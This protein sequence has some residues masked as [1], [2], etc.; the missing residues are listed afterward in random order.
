MQEQTSHFRRPSVQTIPWSETIYH[1][2]SFADPDGRVFLWEGD[3]YRGVFPAAAPFFRKLAE[4]GIISKL[5]EQGFLVDTELTPFTSKEFSLVFR[6]QIVP[7]A[8]YPQEWCSL[9]F[10]DAALAIVDFAIELAHD[11]LIL[12]DGHPWNILFDTCKPLYIDLGSIAPVHGSSIWPAYPDFCRYCLYPL[13]LMSQGYDLLGRLLMCEDRGVRE[14]ELFRLAP[15][16]AFKAYI[17]WPVNR[18][19]SY[20]EK[21]LTSMTNPLLKKEPTTIT[22]ESHSQSRNQKKLLSFLKQLR[23]LVESIPVSTFDFQKGV[24]ESPVDSAQEFSDVRALNGEGMKRLLTELHPDS[25]LDINSGKGSLAKQAASLGVRVVCFE[26]DYG[27]V[28]HLYSEAKTKGLSILPLV[29]DFTKP[30][31]ARGLGSHWAIAATERLQCDLV[32]ALDLLNQP[33]PRRL[34]FDK[35][36][37]GLSQFTK[38]W[39]VLEIPLV[40]GSNGTQPDGFSIDSCTRLLERQ[41]RNI[42]KIYSH[43]KGSMLLVC[44]K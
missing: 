14:R 5:V 9:M 4:N 28:S 27:N 12:K 17:R 34:G 38:R 19:L 31:P 7:F 20:T 11:D 13:I 44:E 32:L 1:P 18:M 24:Q 36:I 37:S 41:F 43:V 35:I 15:Q 42:T 21:Y 8:S 22:S 10:K 25:I 2:H 33:T 3:L 30:T 40:P 26:T 16:L 29:M 39:L 6:H 23:R